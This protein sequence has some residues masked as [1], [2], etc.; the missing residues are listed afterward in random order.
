MMFTS[1]DVAREQGRTR[2]V[3]MSR[4]SESG[5]AAAVR[6]FERRAARMSRRAARI[7]RRAEQMAARAR[8]TV[9]RTM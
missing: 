4:A 6:R 8:L 5:R 3:E 9:A 2:H 7:S 1:V